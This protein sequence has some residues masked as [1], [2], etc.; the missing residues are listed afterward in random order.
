MS[1]PKLPA[2]CTGDCDQGRRDCTCGRALGMWDDE[3][4]SPWV[5]ALFYAMAIVG[6][7]LAS[8]LY[9]WGF[10]S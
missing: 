5:H 6:A 8:H 10:A 1:A 7:L 9:A 4:G 3:R 2:G